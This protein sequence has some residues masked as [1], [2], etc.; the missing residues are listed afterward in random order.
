FAG[1]SSGAGNVAVGD[2]LRESL[3]E[4]MVN[5]GFSGQ[6][7]R[8]LISR[9]PVGTDRPAAMSW[10]RQEIAKKVPVLSNEDA[11]FD[12]GGVLALIGPT[13]VGK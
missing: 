9:L 10:I 11:L 3:F 4:W 8:T 2:P 7:S 12:Q 1:L 6:L 13:G 5:A